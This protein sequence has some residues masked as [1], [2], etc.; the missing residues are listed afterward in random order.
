[1]ADDADIDVVMDLDV[2]TGDDQ[3]A[4]VRSFAQKS[5]RTSQAY[6]VT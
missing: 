5:L 3:L 4:A 2:S 6:T 1:M